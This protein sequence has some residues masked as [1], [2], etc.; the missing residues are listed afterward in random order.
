LE[1]VQAIFGTETPFSLTN[2]SLDLP[3]LQG[4]PED[5]AREKCKLAAAQVKGPVMVE[6][7]SLC[8][9]AL[10]GLPGVYIKVSSSG[11]LSVGS[12]G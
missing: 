1:E 2:Q 9:N 6:D 8:F 11:S 3:E 4:E 7:T 12:F 10:G 5:V